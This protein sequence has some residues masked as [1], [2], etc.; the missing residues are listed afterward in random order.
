MTKLA[1]SAAFA[2]IAAPAFAQDMVGDAA[3]GETEFGRQCVTCHI[4]AND[5]GEVLAGRNAN[6]GPNLHGVVGRQP[7]SVEDFRYGDAL[8]ALGE[9][10]VVWTEETLAAYVQDTTG[11]L[12]AELD[13]PRARSK[14]TYK[15]RD[16]QTALDI[17]AYLATFSPEME[18][19]EGA[20][21]METDGA[22]AETETEETGTGN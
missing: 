10:E 21:E 18:E 19:T 20:E 22:E 16:E 4:V 12:R 7:G 13:D 17:S 6:I 1:L 5:D 11:Y 8:V 15:V 2:L 9:T 14:M 3:A